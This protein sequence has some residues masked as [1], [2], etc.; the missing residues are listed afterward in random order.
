MLA[1]GGGGMAG[2]DVDYIAARSINV[3]DVQYCFGTA[4]QAS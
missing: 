4:S 2:H 3:S 1:S